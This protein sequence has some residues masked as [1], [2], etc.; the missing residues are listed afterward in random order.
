MKIVFN[1]L[2]NQIDFENNI[3]SIEVENKNYLFRIIEEFNKINNGD[4]SESISVYDKKYNEIN[5]KNKFDLYFDYFNLDINNKKIQIKIYD[6]IINNVNEEDNIRIVNQYNKIIKI[7]NKELSNLNLD[8]SI[9]ED[10]SCD[11][12]IKS[13]KF[14]I[15][16]KDSL[17]ENLLQL[18]DINALFK[19]NEFLILVN[20]KQ[21]LSKN[22]LIEL[23]KYSTYNDVKLLLIDSLS[24]GTTIFN[25]KKLIIDED[26]NEFMI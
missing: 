7:F 11:S 19:L 17:L 3:F 16:K 15:E 6:Y 20:L 14:N 5:I 1:F 8:I 22:E 4:I 10:I 13:I 2:D 25:E 24:Y 26:L 23:Y 9:N 21:Y 18:I 12:I